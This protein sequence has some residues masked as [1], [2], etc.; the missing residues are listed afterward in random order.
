MLTF[1]SNPAITK[2]DIFHCTDALL[3]S[4]EHRASVR[5]VG[6]IQIDGDEASASM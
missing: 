2:W 3:H 1:N 5:V 4:P 6:R